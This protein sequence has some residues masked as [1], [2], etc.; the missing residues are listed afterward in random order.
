MKIR[1]LTA[2][3]LIFCAACSDEDA[4]VDSEK[5][6]AAKSEAEQKQSDHAKPAQSLPALESTKNSAQSVSDNSVSISRP[7]ETPKPGTG[8]ELASNDSIDAV[9]LKE[10]EASLARID[11]SKAMDVY[12]NQGSGI[13]LQLGGSDLS[14]RS[15]SVSGAISIQGDPSG[16]GFTIALSGDYLFEFNKDTLTDKAQKALENVLKLY[17]EY[18]GTCIAVAGHTDAKGSDEYNLELSTRRASSVKQWFVNAGI[19]I[20]FID[21]QGYGESQSVADNTRDGQDYPAGRALNRRVDIKVKTKKKVNH[22]P[23]ISKP[24]PLP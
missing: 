5:V 21:S 18:Q 13:T 7:P 10:L 4:Q 23:T 9:L 20:E 12:G 17:T 19:D 14:N 15:I 6:D 2:L 3:L 1:I 11:D 8:L 22:L 16:F 24:Q